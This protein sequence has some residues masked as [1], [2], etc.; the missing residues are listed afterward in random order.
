MFEAFIHHDFPRI[1]RKVRIVERPIEL[2]LRDRLVGGVVVRRQ[3]GV[4]KRVAGS[5][6]LLRVEDKHVLEQI[7]GYGNVSAVLVSVG[8]SLLRT[9]RVR[10]LELVGKRLPFTLGQ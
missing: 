4:R 3:V 9:E 6:T 2:L 1:D 8:Q 7:D 10:I 5:Y